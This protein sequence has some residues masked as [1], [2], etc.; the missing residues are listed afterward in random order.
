MSQK[1]FF[2]FT[3]ALFV[4]GAPY[5]FSKTEESVPVS[6]KATVIVLYTAQ[7]HTEKQEFENLSEP[8]QFAFDQYELESKNKLG[9]KIIPIDDKDNPQYALAAIK[10]VAK[11]QK[12][13]A[14]VG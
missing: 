7:S 9:I 12:P 10:K 13:L 6:K 11:E 2:I 5:G 14:I 1:L 8:A 3:L 4:F